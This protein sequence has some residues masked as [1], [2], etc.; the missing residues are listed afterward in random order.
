MLL[1]NITAKEIKKAKS[2][3]VKLVNSLRKYG[4][5][6][7]AINETIKS[8]CISAADINKDQDINKQT[9]A[10]FAEAMKA[11]NATRNRV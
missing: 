5:S 3:N 6:E 2:R 1:K 11:I 8:C 9:L 4:Y 10:E 7:A